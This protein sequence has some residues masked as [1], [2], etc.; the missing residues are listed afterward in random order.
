[1]DI[2]SRHEAQKRADRILVFREELERLEREGVLALDPE[3]RR[4]VR[5]HHD[6]LLA[7][8][9]QSFDID[10]DSRAGQ[11]SLGMRIASFFGALALSASVFFLF[12]QFW[13][14]LATTT[15]VAILVAAPLAML[16]VTLFVQRKDSSGYFAKLSALVTFAC[17]V[18]DISM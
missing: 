5:A 6:D 3:Q 17:F 8:Y 7:Q 2:P 18:L 13:G 12:Y 11:L 9:S 15:Q 16:A 14:L 10:R 4:R 1:M